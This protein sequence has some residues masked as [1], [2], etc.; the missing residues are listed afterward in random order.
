[1]MIIDH[2]IT[3]IGTCNLDDGFCAYG[4]WSENTESSFINGTA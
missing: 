2:I 4:V 1:M 3:L